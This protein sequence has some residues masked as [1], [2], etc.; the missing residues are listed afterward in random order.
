MYFT[1]K[2]TDWKPNFTIG[3]LFSSI[4]SRP[5]SKSEKLHAVNIGC[6]LV[7]SRN[8]NDW[9]EVR[10][11]DGRVGW[12]D[13]V[14]WKKPNIISGEVVVNIAM[15]FLGVPYLWGGVSTHGFDCSGFVQTVFRLCDIF[16]P[17]DSQIQATS[18]AEIEPNFACLKSGDLLF[19]AEDKKITHVAIYIENGR[20]VHSSGK[21]QIN[22]LNENDNLFHPQ[23]KERL[24]SVRRI[25]S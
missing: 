21:V 10:L 5:D 22:S 25:L 11:P 7:F 15:P 24:H 3:E 20:F 18:G 19:F 17:R 6:N 9:N 2:T 1:S 8:E 14:A 4:Y 12:T 23:L 13:S 16:L